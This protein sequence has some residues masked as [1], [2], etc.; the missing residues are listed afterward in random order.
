MVMKMRLNRT[1]QATT[2][3]AILGSLLLIA[4]A[5]MLR[6]G[7]IMAKQQ[8]LQMY[9]FRKALSKIDE[10]YDRGIGRVSYS[11]YK[12]I[13]MVDLFAKY[14]DGRQRRRL[15]ASNSILWDNDMMVVEAGAGGGRYIQ[16]DGEEVNLGDKKI[17]DI[18][19]LPLVH[20][21]G[22]QEVRK[23]LP[24]GAL[25]R[26]VALTDED[27]TTRLKFEDGGTMDIPT[28]SATATHETWLTPWEQ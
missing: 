11:V 22:G 6:Y 18:E 5:G 13:H 17:E 28:S 26:R 24:E 25:S 23:I 14:Y 1:G 4:L 20:F 8:E 15:S 10:A 3:M 9:S 21:R 16:I 7:Q 27:I 19:T 2:E 12:D